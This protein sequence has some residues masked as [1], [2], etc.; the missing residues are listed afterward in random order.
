MVNLK[1]KLVSA[2]LMTAST[3]VCA[4]ERLTVRDSWTPS[5]LQAGWHWGLEK[6]VFSKAGLNLAYEDGNGSTTTV[7]L[8]GSGQFDVGYADLSVMAVARGKRVPVVSIGGLINKTSLGVFVPKG[9][10]IKDIK[11]LE[12]KEVI[13]TASSFEGPFIDPLLAAG[14]TSRE[15]VNMVSV[16]ASAK[17]STYNAGRGAGMVTSIPFG[18]PYIARA[19]PSDFI[20]FADYGF[21][22]PSYGL[23]VREDT[24]KNKRPALQRLAKAFF[25]SWTAIVEGGEPAI[26]EAADIMIKRR[27]D[28]KLDREQTMSSIREH[29]KYF[30][31]ANTMGKP[32]GIQSEED[33]KMVIKSLETAKLIPA[34]STPQQYFTNDLVTAQ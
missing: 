25:Q 34:G 5:G 24:L 19:R 26:A 33:W 10:G 29:I 3:L 4:Q 9:S 30:R 1:H 16:D 7:Q 6:G 27:P 28:A 22:L 14:G 11:G 32:L 23:V 12:G 2:L 13:Y 15:K 21:V 20:L 18:M 31:T 8:V 17:I